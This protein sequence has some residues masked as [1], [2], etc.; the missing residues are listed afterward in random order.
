[1]PA[2]I[3]DIGDRVDIK[4]SKSDVLREQKDVMKIVKEEFD[5]II[6]NSHLH[7]DFDIVIDEPIKI[8]VQTN[9]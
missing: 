9:Q 5:D 1:M 2:D 8:D 6:Y 7:D 4:K 3:L